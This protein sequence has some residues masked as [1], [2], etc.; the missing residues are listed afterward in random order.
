MLYFLYAIRDAK[1]RFM[2]CN[3][4]V[5]DACA[6]RN[7]EHAVRQPDSLLRSHPADYSLYK[8]GSYDDVGGYVE[9]I[10]PPKLL[11]DAA[12]CLQKEGD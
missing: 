6:V 5:N 2:P 10:N 3:V 8:V 11:C 12:Q 1:S 7:F 9:P 4:D